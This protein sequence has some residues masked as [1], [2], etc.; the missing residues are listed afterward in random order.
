M[1]YRF[2]K[3]LEKKVGLKSWRWRDTVDTKQLILTALHFSS[4]LLK[5]QASE[6]E[7]MR[8]QKVFVDHCGFTFAGQKTRWFVM[9]RQ[10]LQTWPLGMYDLLKLLPVLAVPVINGSRVSTSIIHTVYWNSRRR[11]ESPEAHPVIYSACWTDSQWQTRTVRTL[12]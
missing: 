10:I 7:L 12:H 5:C 2:R 3:I 9:C 11:I 6:V 4:D 8:T 1:P